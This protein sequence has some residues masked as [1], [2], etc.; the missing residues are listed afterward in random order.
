[1]IG[2]TISHYRVVE[3]IGG[4]GMG[5]VYRAIDVKLDRPVA[6]KFL[7]ESMA[8]DHAALERFQR[9][10]RAASALNHPNICTIYEIDE[11][12]GQTFIAM[13]FLDGHTLKQRIAR[14]PLALDD[15]L[16]VGIQVANALDAAHARGII[17]RD[18]KP[19][20]IFC[21]RAGQ[22]KVL[23][24]G[25]AKILSPQRT[26]A[27]ASMT[28]SSLPTVSAEEL[29]SSPGSAMGTVMYMSPEQAMGEELDAR[30]DLFSFGA[31]LYEMA[32][33]ALPF[34]GSTSAAIF[35][36]ILHKSPVPPSRLNPELPSELERIINKALEKDRRLR[37]QH[38]S[39]LRADLQRLKR[40]TD[41][42]RA[43]V[44]GQAGLSA[45]SNASLHESVLVSSSP[46]VLPAGSGSGRTALPA[47]ARLSRVADGSGSST[48]AEVVRQH[49]GKLVVVTL[50]VLALIAAAAYGI[51]ALIHARAIAPF[52]NFTVT[53]LTNNGRVT[54]A[55]ISPDS[56]YLLSVVDDGGRESLW[57]RNLPTNSDTQVIAPADAFYSSVAFSPDGN[58]IYA[59]RAVD[60][61][62]VSFELLRA[63]L[64]GVPQVI[65]KNIDS[66]PS[67]SPD[68]SRI[69]FLRANV[70]QPGDLQIL[71]ARSDG[72]DETVFRQVPSPVE[73]DSIAWSPDGKRLAEAI[74][75]A[76]DALS[77]LQVDS[78]L[79]RKPE[80]VIRMADRVLMHALWLPNGRGL[81]TR[82]AEKL[83]PVAR[84][85]IGYISYP[86][87]EFTSITRDTND[88]Q[89]L[90]LS[91][92]GQTIATVQRKASANLFLL[93][94]AGFAGSPPQPAP[95]QNRSSFAFGWQNDGEL[96]FDDGSN[97]L[98]MARDGSARRMIVSEPAGQ[99]LRPTRCPGTRYVTFVRT[100]REGNGGANVWRANDDGSNPTQLTNSDFD[101]AP[102]CSPDGK[103]VYYDRGDT[104]Q[105]IMRAPVEGGPAETVPGTTVPEMLLAALQFDIS[106]DQ[107]VLAMLM[108]KANASDT[109]KQIALVP[110][111]TGGHP[112]VRWLDPDPRIS[113]NPIFTPD[114][115]AVVY[116]VRQNGVDNL[117]QQPLDG[118]SGR[119]ITNFDSDTIRMAQYSPDGKTLGVLQVHVESDVVL[120]R[121]ASA[122]K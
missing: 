105:G 44:M 66:D 107:S 15:V 80:A 17:H 75:G 94:A 112:Q 24:F 9:E 45:D 8:G 101:I 23:D 81:I 52:Q 98:R 99:I 90:S 92:D 73:I 55:A 86:G 68:G 67:F 106:P 28:A 46:P 82:Y 93:P 58:Y 74:N 39:D 77:E 76:K 33:G 7:P 18:I 41:S 57:L 25:L 59:V 6:L 64:F 117:W 19:A 122:A 5:V 60:N 16:D 111:G 109:R 108:S 22:V 96:F 26:G 32:T 3:K 110:L 1:M 121:D 116:S 31:V 14:G 11:V 91:A 2:Q 48:A 83:S 4:G 56:K 43:R 88:Y 113:A 85:Q 119:Q 21:T 54:A 78:F 115:K 10:A 102:V 79:S 72:R 61:T 36:A 104:L 87:G 97:L 62:H 70:I 51:Y 40:D 103:W 42:G 89:G 35:D 49:K 29:L 47:E 50:L 71:T 114:G 120:L 69:V 20:N 30:T 37:Y 118:G 34:W 38:A 100:G 13:E 63:P 84:F 95:A 12:Q 53:Q 65:V 27:G